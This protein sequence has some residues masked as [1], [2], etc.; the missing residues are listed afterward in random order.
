MNSQRNEIF[1]NL[2]LWFT[3][4][5]QFYITNETKQKQKKIENLL[6]LEKILICVK[7]NL[8]KCIKLWLQIPQDFNSV[9]KLQISY[10]NWS[11]KLFENIVLKIQDWKEE[12][13]IF[14]IF[15]PVS[16][17]IFCSVVVQFM[18]KWLNH[19]SGKA[20]NPCKGLI[21]FYLNQFCLENR[22]MRFFFSPHL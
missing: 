17:K 11:L 9:P 20:W 7:F 19:L 4:H 21:I 10:F 1:S 18:Q 8:N 2:T 6:V 15:V 12:F 13:S 16:D 22:S 5:E 3:N 14:S